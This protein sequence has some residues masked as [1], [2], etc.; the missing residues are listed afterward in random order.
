VNVDTGTFQALTAE[1]AMLRERAAR[2]RHRAPRKRQPRRYSPPPHIQW[3][4]VGYDVA[5]QEIGGLMADLHE[6]GS[7]RA[8]TLA[9]VAAVVAGRLELAGPEADWLR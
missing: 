1:T 3:A 7:G 4:E 6:S 2:G 9:A 8:G 5:M